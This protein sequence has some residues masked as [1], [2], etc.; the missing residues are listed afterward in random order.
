MFCSQCGT[1]LSN[2]SRF[3][4]SCGQMQ[5]VVSTGGG[6]AAAAAPARSPA[7]EEKHNSG[8]IKWAVLIVLLVVGTAL[9]LARN[10]VHRP[11]DLGDRVVTVR[12]HSWYA[13][14]FQVPYDG[15]LT[16]SSAVQSGNPLLMYLTNPEGYQG[17]EISDRNTY[18]EGFAAQHSLNFQHTE[19]VT[20]GTYYFVVRDNSLG[21]LSQPSTDAAVKIHL[22]P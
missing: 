11:I 7:R 20:K 16:I 22:E 18:W 4:R 2:D 1:D 19:R 14:T 3:C 12:A 6:A 21:I 17:L 8:A 9:L 5:G 15:S 10:V 13:V